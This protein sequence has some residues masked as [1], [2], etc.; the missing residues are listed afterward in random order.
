MKNA[1]S[2][3]TTKGGDADVEK[4]VV[5]GTPVSGVSGLLGLHTNHKSVVSGMSQV[6]YGTAGGNSSKALKKFLS[7]VIVLSY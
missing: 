4:T 2:P 3:L 5:L 1:L 7:C 6:Y